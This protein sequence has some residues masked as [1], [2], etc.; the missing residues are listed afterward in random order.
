M[1]RPVKPNRAFEDIVAQIQ[2]S[3][4]EGKLNPG[5]QLPA[6]RHLRE[7]FG[8]S[9][10]TLR[11]ALRTLEQKK[12]IQIKPGVKGGAIVRPL[13]TQPMSESLELLLRYQRIT[14][15]ELA[16]F[17]ETMEGL[18]AALVARRARKGSLKPLEDLLESIRRHLG[19]K[20]PPWD[21]I[22]AEDKKFHLYVVG[23]AQNR[24]FVSILHTVYDN[25]H[26]YLDRFLP[27]DAKTLHS[28]YGDLCEIVQALRERDGPR[29]QELVE[30]HVRRFTRIVEKWNP[31]KTGI[32]ATG[33][34]GTG[35]ETP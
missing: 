6:E 29:A 23:L 13:D 1:F 3:I 5:D 18:V 20:E 25:I 2:E 7:V 15:R 4:L 27:R 14:L 17:R 33:E 32:A 16:E 26:E 35:G 21:E 22:L 28:L 30:R 11:E 24:I 34:K 10:G 19:E 8:V 12:L 9:R 31:S